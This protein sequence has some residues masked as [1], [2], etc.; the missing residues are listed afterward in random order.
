M[1]HGF[2]TK[3][4]AIMIALLLSFTM[5]PGELV[6]AAAMSGKVELNDNLI[7]YL[8]DVYG[9][10]SAAALAQNLE[11]M[12][13]LDENGQMRTY[14]V[15][16]NGEKLS[17]DEVK[18]I[19]QD[20]EIDLTQTCKV[21]GQEITLEDLNALLDIEEELNRIQ[22][23]YFST[24]VEITDEHQ[25]AFQSLVEQLSETGLEFSVWPTS[26]QDDAAVEAGYK[27]QLAR[28][29]VSQQSVTVDQGSDV[30]FTFSL[31]KELPYTVSFDYKT[32]D[33]A[34]IAGKH[35]EAVSG[36]VTFEAGETTKTITVKTKTVSAHRGEQVSSDVYATDR[37][38]G[39]RPFLVQCYNPKNVLF[40]GDKSS[41][42]L[43]ANINGNYDYDMYYLN[44]NL[45]HISTKYNAVPATDSG[46]GMRQGPSLA[47]EVKIES[48][49]ALS[50]TVPFTYNE[51]ELKE[52]IREGLITHFTSSLTYTDL[53]SGF[54]QIYLAVPGSNSLNSGNSNIIAASSSQSGDATVRLKYDI[55]AN[56]SKFL[57]SDSLS[58]GYNNGGVTGKTFW[59]E[60]NFIYEKTLS[61]QSVTAPEGIYYPGD[62]V[63]ITVTYN[64]PIWK[65]EETYLTI[66]GQKIYSSA[67]DGTASY[68]HTFLYTVPDHPTSQITIE[69]LSTK[70]FLAACDW[71]V[72]VV[73]PDEYDTY[74]DTTE[75]KVSGVSLSEQNTQK[76]FTG[77]TLD[78]A[79]Y[80]PK[81]KTASITVGIDTA[82]SKWLEQGDMADHVKASIDGGKTLIDLTLSGDGTAM[83][84][85]ADLPT[86]L[87]GAD[88][89]MRVELYFN[90]SEDSA[91]PEYYCIL[92][93]YADF[94]VNPVIFAQADEMSIQY[95]G[96][97]V[98][99]KEDVVYLTAD[100][101]TQLNYSYNGDATYPEFEWS[102]N[103]EEVAG[104]TENGTILP[105]SAGTV[106]FRLT[107][108]NADMDPDQ[109]AF[110][111]TR[112]I[113]IS[114]GGEPSLVIPSDLS[115]ITVTQGKDASL[116]WSTN[117]IYK[118]QN[119]VDP[120]VDTDFT[121][122][123]YQ[124]N[125]DDD[126]LA[127]AQPI[128]IYR[129][130]EEYPL[131]NVTS[132]M[133]PKE[134]ITEISV[135]DVP[136]YTV[137]VE[138]KHPLN[139][140]M[141]QAKAYIVVNSPA[142][143]VE[144]E[145]PSNIYLLDSRQSIPV[146][147]TLSY[148]DSK[149]EGEFE[150]SVT[151]N[152]TLINE[153]VITYDPEN[154]F[155]FG[156]EQVGDSATYQGH[157][158]IPVKQV[159][160]GTLYDLYTVNIKAKNK[161]DS[162]WSY[163]SLIFYVY[164][165]DA[166]DILVG[167]QKEDN[168]LLSN[169]SNISGMS[170]AEILAL[171][172]DINL[173]KTISIN[174]G[175]YA[176]AQ[177]T[178]KIRWM[179]T[180]SD[181]A[182]INYQQGGIYD[183][184]E[185]YNYTTYRPS[186]E[187]ILS[188]LKDGTAT[189]KAV[190]D[191]TGMETSV[192]VSV[193]TLKDKLY[194][195]QI[196]PKTTTE[197]VY[198]N[199]NGEQQS[200]TTDENGALAVYE[201]SGIASDV[202]LK[203]TYDEK[204]YIG[205]ITAESL[206]SGEQ[207]ASKM[208]LYPVNN[209]RLREP[210][211]VTFYLK[212]PDGT[213][214]EG[215]LTYRGGVY[216][217]GEYCEASEISGEGKTVTIGQD[218]KLQIQMDVTTFWVNGNQEELSA[219]DEL[220]FV[221]EVVFPSDSYAPLL[222]TQNSR[223]NADDLVSTAAANVT[224]TKA[225][226]I[227]PFI[228]SQTYYAD[229][230][231]A[232]KRDILGYTGKLGP[233]SDQSA[234]VVDTTILWWGEDPED[235]S[236]ACVELQDEFGV[237]P[238]GQS[239]KTF[240]Y[241][242][243]TMMVTKHTQ[244]LNESTL[245]MEQKYSRGIQYQLKK[246]AVTLYES[247][248]VSFR[249]IN[250]TGISSVL[251]KDS[252]TTS[253]LA[254]IK[255][256][257]TVDGGSMGLSDALIGAGIGVLEDISFSTSLFTMQIAAT[258]DPTRFNV[259]IQAG[260]GN[261]DGDLYFQTAEDTQ[262]NL[263][264]GLMDIRSMMKGE[265]LDN[266]EKE[267]DEVAKNQKG[268]DKDIY[269]N[270]S[271]YYEGEIVYNYEEDKWE[272]IVHGGGFNVGGGMGYHWFFNSWVGPVPVTAELGLG[273]AV[274]VDFNAKALYEERTYDGELQ[275]W[276]DSVDSDY[277]TDYLSTLRVYAY[278]NAFGGLGF[279]YSV[280]ALKIGLFGEIALDNQNTWL[281]REY[282]K[283]TD[284]QV[285]NGQSLSLHGQVGIR[286]YAA[287]LFI[288]YETVLASSEYTHTW[289][290]NN[291]DKI[292]DY[293]EKT[294]GGSLDDDDILQ[295]TLTYMIANPQLVP[296]SDT[297]T[298]ESRDYLSKAQ[299][300][301]NSYTEM[302]TFSLDDP[303]G[304]P[305]E[306]QS[307]A[308]PHANPE[309]TD[310]G[311]MFVYLSDSGNV[312][313]AETSASY[314]VYNGAGYT[315]MGSIPVDQ[316][317]YGDS[318][319]SV[320]GD[321]QHAVAVWVQ[322]K[323]ELQKDAGDTL[324]P[325]EQ[326]LLVNA[327]EIVVGLYENGT[328]T[329]QRLTDNAT[330]DLAPVVATNGDDIFVAWR[331]VVIA[332]ENHVTDFSGSDQI[333][334]V[335]YDR[336][337]KTWSEPTT[338]YNGTSGSVLGL[339]SEMLED[340]T[341][342][343][344]YTL[345]R[346]PEQEKSQSSNY[347]IVY[348][349]VDQN[350][351]VVKNQQLTSDEALDE[352]PQ[353]TTAVLNGTEQ[354]VLGWYR[355]EETS[356]DQTNQS[357][358]RLA[359]VDRLG[360]ITTADVGLSDS[361][362]QATGGTNISVDSNFRFVNAQS[363][364]L[365][366]LSLVWASVQ[367]DGEQQT[368]VSAAQTGILR[369]VRFVEEDGRIHT[370]GVIDIAQMDEGVLIDTF[371]VYNSGNDQ[372]KALILGSHYSGEED[373]GITV[374]DPDTGEEQPLLLP[375]SISGMYTATGSYQDAF[376]IDGVDADLESM[377]R[378]LPLPVKFTISNNGIQN[379][380]RVELTVG[381]S[382]RVFDENEVLIQ[383]NNSAELTLDYQVPDDQVV[384]PQ[385]SVKVTFT[386]GTTQ[387]FT[388][389][390][391]LTIPDVGI[392][393]T[394]IIREEDGEREF[395]VTLYNG[396]ET[397]I[398]GTGQVVK[399][400]FFTDSGCTESIPGLDT[401][402]IS[403]EE[404]L[405]L[406]DAGAYTKQ[407]TFD[408]Y[409]YL[410]SKGYE[411]VPDSGIPVYLKAW[412]EK[413]DQQISEYD[414]VNNNEMMQFYA[415]NK[416]LESGSWLKDTVS[417]T[418]GSVTTA[419]VELQNLKM[420]SVSSW[421]AVINLLDQNGNVIETQYFTT[422]AEGLIQFG[423]EQR[424]S[425]TIQF[426]HLGNS[427]E[428]IPFE[429]SASQMDA[430]LSS[431]SASG[432]N[433]NFSA[434]VL[435]YDAQAENLTQ[436]RVTAIASSK[437][438]TVAIYDAQGNQL[439]ES[440]G[441]ATASVPL[442]YTQIN[443]E[444]TGKTNQIVVVVTPIDE[445]A[446]TQTYTVNLT[447]LQKT[448]GTVSV[449][450]PETNAGGWISKWDQRIQITADGDDV[451]RIEY[452]FDG[453][454]WNGQDGNEIELDLPEVDGVYT[455]YARAQD[456]TGNYTNSSPATLRLD[457]EAPVITGDIVLEETDIP[458]EKTRSLTNL[459][460]LFDLST[461]HQVKLTATVS[462]SVSGIHQLTAL[463]EDGKS[464]PLT[465]NGDG[466]YSCMITHAYEGVLTVTAVDFAGNT[467]SKSTGE[468]L[469][470]DEVPNPTVNHTAG[471]VTQNSAALDVSVSYPDDKYFESVIVRYKRQTDSRWTVAEEVTDAADAKNL[472]VTL[473][474]LESATAYEYRIEVQNAVGDAPIVVIGTFVT[475]YPAPKAPELNFRD[476]YSIT[477]KEVT[478][479]VYRCQTD[480]GQ[481]IWT[482]WTADPTFT[483]LNPDTEYTFQMKIAASGNIPESEASS[484]Q[485]ST[486]PLYA[487]S[488]S[489]NTT[490]TV[491]DMPA[492]QQVGYGL[493]AVSPTQ[494]PTRAGYT[495]TGWYQEA[496]C[497]NLYDFNTK[498]TSEQTVYA[499]WSE[500]VI[501]SGDYTVEG[502]Q[503]NQWYQTDV[504]IKPAG[505]YTQIWNGTAWADSMTVRDGKDQQVTFKL[506]K[507][508]N[509]K[510]IETTF[511]HD[512][513]ELS[514]DTVDPVGTLTVEKNSFREFLHTITFGLFFSDTVTASLSSSDE[515]SGIAKNEYL[516]ANEPMNLDALKASN[517]WVEGTSV[518][519]EPEDTYVV[520][521]RVTDMAGRVTYLSTDGIVIDETI[522]VVHV[523]YAADGVWTTSPNAQIS[524]EVTEQL[525]GIK[526]VQYTVDGEKFTTSET[527]FQISNLPDGNYD[528]VIT[529]F[530]QSSNTSIP[531]TVHVMKE[532][533]LPGLT[534]EKNTA[535]STPQKVV[536]NLMPDGEYVSGV[537]IYVS[538]DGGTEVKLAADQRIYT[539]TENGTYTF[540]MLT[541][542]GQEA[543]SSI[544]IDSIEQAE[545]Q[546]GDSPTVIVF[547]ISFVILAAVGMAVFI[548]WRRKKRQK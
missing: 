440:T 35:Y 418:N 264:P 139:D 378:G 318:N 120:P 266:Q 514:V 50:Y 403:S 470:D 522:P 285:M 43:Q 265:Y 288:S 282:L 55:Q 100:Q 324:T 398:A 91:N 22:S 237:V 17:L 76:T 545:L 90:S 495:F 291:W 461:N 59:N 144:M 317:G 344:V 406:L 231:G 64:E 156:M 157:Y 332:D 262:S 466:T 333:V 347:E 190:H 523:D 416:D 150:F 57:S 396:S 177:V 482:E 401:V 532:S 4:T 412:I 223:L 123:L 476:S 360:A 515:T 248:P 88:R 168:T 175:D 140:S 107:A 72:T 69:G 372:L 464:Y 478:G 306:L 263:T 298:L 329:T 361:L 38:E 380:K 267:L 337:T 102:S 421:N 355:Q 198:T 444:S 47:P 277:V 97:W 520:Y 44:G 196:S 160:S 272:T 420:Q 93:Q 326:A 529:A 487:V 462:D 9:E 365:E 41:L 127:S 524:V 454:T 474:G 302:S 255:D 18:E 289:V 497:Q 422:D 200:R 106:T 94:V 268:G 357:D 71:V 82:Y 315:D 92:G 149:N 203:S 427:V 509:G 469:I 258:E 235:L 450:L 371:S 209:L 78:A 194:I 312:D 224:L 292:Q 460:G 359:S 247:L 411:E 143:V 179:S 382:N 115:K 236:E 279:D 240:R 133:I 34:A 113:T 109:N 226:Q 385:Y 202:H 342:A 484:V 336:Q 111:D 131:R 104:I 63:P 296:V 535:D 386:D 178:D 475:T 428:V 89:D 391:R 52:Y 472:S 278:L 51:V 456:S 435:S 492:Q 27:S 519:L 75:R 366:N 338:L 327:S 395:T 320:A 516:V 527:E 451:E 370:S 85:T 42:T 24:D 195:F 80:T 232:A 13:L 39:T 541:G 56:S 373:S 341:A 498:V 205:T 311:Q 126:A 286:F 260:K 353:I 161:K 281:N 112:T 442:Q 145:K 273:A 162:T 124:G 58:F 537:T 274:A 414:T 499:G 433:I 455:V 504:V 548:I 182:S 201:E 388:D 546:M 477:L 227:K 354:F 432:V 271:G 376:S 141:L 216:K 159:S 256:Q 62:V 325:A 163:E 547:A 488:F 66:S 280:V 2:I 208:G 434:D 26:A 19:L 158:E 171:N 117:V 513:L 118:N 543:V 379:I 154:G 305:D 481:D 28:V 249:V 343:I 84:G 220:E 253:I 1:N 534:V 299:R 116:F 322:Q 408:L 518:N 49:N 316:E 295:A 176:W 25:K 438:S 110:I 48:G 328:W 348:A 169:I 319:L 413:N 214:Y 30:K 21:D 29:S 67:A 486:Y 20:P 425:K 448:A 152:D 132:F 215:E 303:N 135:N 368:A 517:G 449:T 392:S 351:E 10:E 239:Y 81:Q 261:M 540:R 32:L 174:Y 539:V 463:T 233:N 206:A 308:Y 507:F 142:A 446:Q 310:D 12:G 439:T 505:E 340:G 387:T 243:G 5:I 73:L 218:G 230:D 129:N 330:P 410:T 471:E 228:A 419:T 269:Y 321:S 101:S 14:Q 187:F 436:T 250:M 105:R 252:G 204:T 184:I 138:V 383:P 65:G 219:D 349:V 122:K 458:L 234:T 130:S 331:S 153:S 544:T 103:N 213:P 493:Q 426:S 283:N 374:P 221:Y 136:S 350:Q 352:N 222:L 530:D 60:G 512:P 375:V 489:A 61:V 270:V 146:D 465:A 404:E 431:L 409:S 165:S 11:Q 526:E 457:R 193:E 452:S 151:R 538:K 87:D 407:I 241:P 510:V 119:D 3:I 356:D 521:A 36:T 137:T 186:E 166:L 242:F 173:G 334:A 531:V 37:W 189:I 362:S 211:N 437:E 207:D 257:M 400:G 98:S 363:P 297:A 15:E 16:Y 394:S 197:V 390:L 367:T 7:N 188:G 335:R 23:T 542:A 307:N 170:S 508:E 83:T 77:I 473:S 339:Q 441:V 402:T 323:T 313:V 251:D 254:Q 423:P 180:D 485:L 95:P 503:K 276:D 430:D 40:D 424:V 294:T 358:I 238:T 397:P 443:G 506:R 246:D 290:Y 309:L 225:D 74:S 172:R 99:G 491:I 245:W 8:T 480:A 293:W 393:K 501:Q 134:D 314:A 192:N 212:K 345:D 148:F 284:A 128:K 108:T 147:W 181:T 210:A 53:S 6:S 381:E 183:R 199:G 417:L 275:E 494:E 389:T 79:S 429:S 468:V 405:A 502:T 453:T 483:G 96:E 70:R 384:D 155:T 377:M 121:V 459:F 31:S 364:S 185:N 45:I 511:L 304:A 479:A 528:V 525:S 536:L 301:W 244:K 68:Q 346:S 191:K 369:A 229:I 415:L 287:F 447:N 259:L 114:P 300:N 399:L 125:L 533:T 467:S 445:A 54:G 496:S 500:N 86:V 217:N 164:N 33:G 46:W 490:D 167:G